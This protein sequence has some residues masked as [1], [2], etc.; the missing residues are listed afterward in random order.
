M[1]LT[2]LAVGENKFDYLEE[3]ESDFLSRL[4]HYCKI[5]MA[6]VQGK[7]LTANVS[8]KTVRDKEWET[9]RKALPTQRYLIVLDRKGQMLSSNELAEKIQNL[10][11]RSVSEVCIVIGGPLGLPDAAIQESD[12]VLSL[13]PMTFTHEMTRLILLEQLYRAFTILRGEKYHK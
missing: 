4:K 10:Q 3:A 7:K 12:F 13:S 5:S 1:R 2:I 9:I 11:I 8:E 6:C